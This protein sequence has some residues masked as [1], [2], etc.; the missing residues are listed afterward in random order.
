M[1]SA[2]HLHP[3][4]RVEVRQRLVEQEHLRIAH[5]RA[6]HGD[7]LPLPAG[8][9]ARITVE[10]WGKAEDFRGAVHLGG[11]LALRR[12]FSF[13]ENAMLSATVMCG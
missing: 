6:P 10:Q 12:V 1:I 11:Y 7:P 3:K 2:A 13:S 4:L 5:D 9:L 8:E